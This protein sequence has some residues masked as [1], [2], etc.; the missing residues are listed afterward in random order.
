MLSQTQALCMAFDSVPS[1]EFSW[2][3]FCTPAEPSMGQDEQDEQDQGEFAKP[4]YP[5]L[6]SHIPGSQ[7][8]PSFPSHQA[9]GII[10]V[11]REGYVVK[12]RSSLCLTSVCVW[13]AD[14]LDER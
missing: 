4:H 9:T 10:V 5:V 12:C 13:L 3:V 14:T 7:S 11:H 1:P 8:F 6:R 2:V